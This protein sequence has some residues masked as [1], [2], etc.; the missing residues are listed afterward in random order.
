V[1]GFDIGS[2]T[3]QQGRTSRIGRD[4]TPDSIDKENTMP[5]TGSERLTRTMS[6]E[7]LYA[8]ATAM[9]CAVGIGLLALIAAIG[10]NGNNDATVVAATSGAGH[11]STVAGGWGPA[12]AR[13]KQVFDQRRARREGA[14]PSPVVAGSTHQYA[15]EHIAP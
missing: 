10:I 14:A 1:A 7:P 5:Q 3:H 9:K 15:V 8:V 2:R 4:P 13:S 6:D 11:A 12:V